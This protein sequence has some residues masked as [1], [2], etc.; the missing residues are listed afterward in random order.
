M[1]RVDVTAYYKKEHEGCC[2]HNT[3]SD[4]AEILEK[5]LLRSIED[6]SIQLLFFCFYY[7]NTLRTNTKSSRPE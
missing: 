1:D 3:S 6:I 2:M 7:G 5:E 4:T